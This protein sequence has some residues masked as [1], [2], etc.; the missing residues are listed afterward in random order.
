MAASS[1]TGSL[2][3]ASTAKQ[4]GQSRQG[5]D[6]GGFRGFAEVGCNTRRAGSAERAALS[7][8]VS[9][10]DFR[11]ERLRRRLPR[12]CFVYATVAADSR[13][14]PSHSLAARAVA[15]DDGDAARAQAADHGRTQAALWPGSGTSRACRNLPPL[16]PRST[17]ISTRNVIFT[18]GRTSNS[19]APPPWPSGV[20]LQPESPRLL[21]LLVRSS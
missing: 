12:A 6:E 11:G 7:V 4:A 17:I 15:G 19:I 21:V 9:D 18:T 14:D 1:E 8:P 5:R 16:T 20:N 13:L 10:L 3:P 2:R